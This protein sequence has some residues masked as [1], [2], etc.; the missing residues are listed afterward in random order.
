MLQEKLLANC[1][2]SRSRRFSEEIF[3]A[4]K[5]RNASAFGCLSSSE[6]EEQEGVRKCAAKGGLGF[7]VSPKTFIVVSFVMGR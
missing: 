6:W 4:A 2:Y 1:K 3:Y 5:R 7:W